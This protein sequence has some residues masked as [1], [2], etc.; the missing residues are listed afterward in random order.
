MG[1]K[2]KT[3]TGRT[4]CGRIKD[5]VRAFQGK[6]KHTMQLGLRVVRCDECE[7]PKIKEE[8]R[9]VETVTIV[10]CFCWTPYTL[11]EEKRIEL[12]LAESLGRELLQQ[13]LIDIKRRELRGTTDEHSILQY[14]AEVQVRRPT[15]EEAKQ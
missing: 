11:E 13:G 14:R 12:R 1:K 9:E 4:F 2:D 5:A 6:P 15:K 3:I 10:N 8:R 7:R